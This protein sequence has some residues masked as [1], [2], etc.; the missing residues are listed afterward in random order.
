MLREVIE[1]RSRQAARLAAALLTL[2]AISAP[3]NAWAQ[4]HFDSADAAMN[5][6][7][8]EIEADD[9][10]AI[11]EILGA[12]Y[13]DRLVTSDWDAEQPARER[14]AAAAKEKLDAK[15]IAD[16]RVEW[17]LGSEEWPFPF[18]AVRGD[19]GSW[20]FDA[21]Q[22]IEAVLDRR[23]G[24]N[25]LSA[26]ALANA[27]VD[28]QIAYAREDRNGNEVL[29]YAQRL[30]STE[31]KRDG[32]YWE[33]A[34][35]EPESPFGPLVKGAETYLD[36]VE[37]GDP[38]RGYYFRV[39][40]RQ[41]EHAPGGAHS[42]MINGNMIAGFALVAYPAEY[43]NTGVMTFIVDHRGVIQQ[44]SIE[45]SEGVDVY[46]PDDSWVEVEDEAKP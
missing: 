12:E 40:D 33:S 34:P 18:Q 26:I 30:A 9:Q 8:V 37:K 16:D 3:G 21:E 10:Q 28:A 7:V 17:I 19:D 2:M 32:L 4:R 6:M 31:G 35:D 25:E 39:L 14:I 24:R 27:Y 22:G 42:Y 45:D 38:I 15:P 46:D 5:A 11:L 20:S 23:I 43:G 36:T 13:K 1:R 29:E 44:K 41:G